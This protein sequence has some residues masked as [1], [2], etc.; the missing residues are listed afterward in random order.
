MKNE[1][2]GHYLNMQDA[3]QNVLQ[4]R[5]NVMSNFL[6]YTV[7][8]ISWQLGLSITHCT[9]GCIL[10]IEYNCYSKTFTVL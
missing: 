4:Y 2:A 8:V 1:N 7:T 9:L 5:A 6:H 3:G 10:H